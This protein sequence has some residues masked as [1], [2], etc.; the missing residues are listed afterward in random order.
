MEQYKEMYIATAEGHIYSKYKNRILKEYENNL[1]YKSVTLIDPILKKKRTVNVHRYIA[2]CL[3]DGYKEGLVVNHIDGN[4]S[5]NIPSNLEWVTQK[6]NIKHAKEI[7]GTRDYTGEKHP[8]YGRK[9]SPET[10][11]K[12]AAIKRGITGAKHWRSTPINMISLD[13]G[14]VLKTFESQCIAAR[15]TGLSQG[16][17]AMVLSGKRNMAGGYRWEYAARGR[18]TTSREA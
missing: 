3:V 4:R 10:I 11:E 15:E 18:S 6:E 12:I 17:I 7:L 8:M 13:T 16:N 5:N 1:G 14:K 9:H 2:Y